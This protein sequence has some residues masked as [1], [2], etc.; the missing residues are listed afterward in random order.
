MFD[1]VCF[2][3]VVVTDDLARSLETGV[4]VCGKIG[5]WSRFQRF[6]VDAD[7]VD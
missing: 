2:V 1:I 4:A 5:D 6:G 3:A 7:V